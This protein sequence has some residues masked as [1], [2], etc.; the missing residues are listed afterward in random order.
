MAILELVLMWLAVQYAQKLDDLDGV[1]RTHDFACN[2]RILSSPSPSVLVVTITVGS[3]GSA[4]SSI[5]K[6]EPKIL[7]FSAT[8]TRAVHLFA[9]AYAGD[10]KFDD[11]LLEPLSKTAWASMTVMSQDKASLDLLGL[12]TQDT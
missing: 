12:V 10:K 7:A 1:Q 9:A 4:N 6:S 8:R 3:G 2:G 11:Q 5:V